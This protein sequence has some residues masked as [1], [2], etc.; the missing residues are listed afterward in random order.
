M[1]LRNIEEH[2]NAA[3][4]DTPVVL[5]NGARQTGKSTLAQ[6]L[7]EALGGRY[8]TLDDAATLAGA[9]RD[10][11]GFIQ[12]IGDK[13]IIDEVQKV[14]G[15]FPAIKLQ[16]DRDRRP[17][18][19][20]LTGSA[21]VF[22][23]PRLAE[24][25]AG[26]VEVVS[27]WPLSRGELLNRRERFI[28]GL[29]APK[30]PALSKGNGSGNDLP[31]KILAGGFPEAVARTESHRRQDWFASYI[32]TI[33]Q[34]DIRDLAHIEGLTDMPHLLALLAARSGGLLN[35]SELSRFSGISHTTL[36]RY[37]TLLETTFLLQPLPAW[38]TNIGKRLV[39][40][41]KAYLID[42]G[43]AAH[44]TGQT[45]PKSLRASSLYGHLL[46]TF[47]VMELRKQAAWNETR[48]RFHHFRTAVGREVDIVLEDPRGQ[49]VGVEV[50]AS[51]SVQERD[52]AG[53]ETL[54]EA[55]GRQFLNGVVLY[56]GDTVV[57]F[58]KRLWAFPVSALWRMLAG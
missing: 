49:V 3:L 36:R 50:K 52:F 43:M 53:L 12:G 33:L 48:V 7:A 51:T 26:R 1:Y 15:L 45:D 39:K 23:L 4:A 24:S 8:L 5:L 10:P 22:M 38:S 25:L 17:G 19:F 40:S 32:T 14:P 58:G 21:N 28:D 16:V 42:S 2:L 20:L 34:R 57:P 9:S 41:P 46:E 30:P 29:F 18:R 37:L 47:V 56:T 11:Q 35:M 13:V 54:A 44:L 6:R 27:L 31:E 55:A